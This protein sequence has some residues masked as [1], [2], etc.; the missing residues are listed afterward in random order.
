MFKKI[1]I[2]FIIII[3]PCFLLSKSKEK[4]KIP[5]KSKK[6]VESTTK[7]SDF[8]VQS[9][10]SDAL[11][12][13]NVTFNRRT[14]PKGRGKELEVNF[15]VINKTDY[16]WKLYVFVIASYEKIIMQK[17]SFG[18]LKDMPEKIE[19]KTLD[20]NIGGIKNFEYQKDG[21]K[22]YIKFPKSIKKGINQETGKQYKLVEKFHVRT[23]HVVRYS[24]RFNFYN[25]V[26]LLIYDDESKL[27]YRQVYKILTK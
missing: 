25:H 18:K 21:K 9:V 19:I 1:V 6:K 22:I 24:K 7:K 5:V 17:T 15:D 26:T 3:F 8:K 11:M 23:Q 13:K 20:V 4:K 2:I 27:M 12:V 16:H 10:Y 14:D